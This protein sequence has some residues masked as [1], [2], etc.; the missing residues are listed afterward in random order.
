[1]KHSLRNVR[2]NEAVQAFVRLGGVERQGKG[3]HKVVN[4]NDVNL[5][6]P[7]GILKEGLLRRLIRISGVTPDDFLREI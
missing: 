4:I 3:S 5:S 2:Q 7:H 6:I 1:M